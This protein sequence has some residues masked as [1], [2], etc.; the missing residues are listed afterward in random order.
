LKIG[1]LIPAYNES[2]HIGRLVKD[3]KLIGLEPTVVDDGSTDS[4]A[5]E[6]RSSG[7]DVIRHAQNLGKGA[8][9]KKGFR[10]MLDKGYDAVLIMDG[11]GQ[12]SP[13]EVVKFIS[14]GDK[15]PN[16]LV[17]GDR[18]GDTKKMP[19]G[20][21]LTNIFM[22]FV[23]SAICGQGIPDSQ[24]GFRLIRKD[25]LEK[26]DIKSSRFEVESEI[27]VKASRAGAKIISVPIESIYAREASQINPLRD[28]YRFVA[29]LI[30]LPFIK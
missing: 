20:R 22:S 15:E 3:I 2:D 29:F 28:T 12:H 24:C 19:L 25:L 7:A 26:I 9:L 16:A 14:L 5:E 10:H 11:D 6:A 13:E 1:I 21:K 8:A 27:L 4:T 30:K 18:M 23:M 17:V